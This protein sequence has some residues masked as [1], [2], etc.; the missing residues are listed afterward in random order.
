MK[1][2]K[3]L[4]DEFDKILIKKFDINEHSKIENL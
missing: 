4:K 3:L 1:K 2:L